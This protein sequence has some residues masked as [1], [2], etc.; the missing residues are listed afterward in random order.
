MSILTRYILSSYFKNYLIS[1]FVLIGLFIVL[2]MVFNFDEF[3]V[4]RSAGTGGWATIAN[5]S[6]YYFYQSFRVF[7]Q[8]SGVIPVAAAAFTFLRLS[9]FNELT[10]M[11]AAG[12]DL[13]RVAFPAIIAAVI[14][15]LVLPAINQELI[16]PNII[17]ELTRSRNES[18]ESRG[19]AYAIQNLEDDRGGLIFVARY[20]PPTPQEG[21][22]MEL[23][24][25][26]QR[27]QDYK[28]QSHIT[29]S[30]ATY[31]EQKNQ[32]NLTNGRRVTG[33]GPGQTRS[34]PVALSVYASSLTPEE[35]AMYRSRD[36]VEMLSTTRINELLAGKQLYGTVDLLR[37]KHA[38]LAQLPLNII[39]VLLAISCVLIREPGMLKTSI[40]KLLFLV[41]AC[42][43]TIFV[44][45]SVA[46]NPPE[47]PRWLDRWPALCA[48]VPIFFF[49]PVSVYLMDRVRT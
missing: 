13:R 38:R 9:R 12:M 33:F 32:W 40:V 43:A 34:M 28:L 6:E 21:A 37:V 22:K 42:M 25:I 7:A 5:M 27:D 3:A 23:V 14:L 19:A 49:G 36:F 1:L 30:S 47:D 18:S 16:I 8:M 15:S 46:G 48:W 2:D 41:G 26:L 39:M 10:A 45:Q 44:F 11:M 17:P 4:Q 20:T 29:A 31:D 35:I 24:D